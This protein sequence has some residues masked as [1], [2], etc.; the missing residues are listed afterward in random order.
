M[1]KN[2]TPVKPVGSKTRQLPKGAMAAAELDKTKLKSEEQIAQENAQK[3]ADEEANKTLVH[4]AMLNMVATLSTPVALSAPQG[5][6]A[7]DT[8]SA[9]LGVPPEIAEK[10]AAELAELQAKFNIPATPVKAARGDKIVHNEI[11]RPGAETICGK[12]WATADRLSKE[13]K[14]I[15]TIAMMQAAPE[16]AGIV[17]ATLKTQYA[18]WRKFNDIKGRLPT[19]ATPAVHQPV[20]EYEG[21]KAAE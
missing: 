18:R 9:K 10:Y 20:G 3:I 1:A 15:A 8:L 16:M 14:T 2:Q 21:L 17:I 19:I 13:N 11:T 12:I 7:G 5:R 6:R 4:D